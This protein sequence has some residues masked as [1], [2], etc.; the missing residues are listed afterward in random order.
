MAEAAAPPPFD[1]DAYVD[2]ASRL[3]GIEVAEAFRPGVAA[4]IALIAQDGG[5]GHGPTPFHRGRA[6]AG[7]RADRARAMIDPFTSGV[8]IATLIRNGEVSAV[9]VAEAALA[10]IAAEDGRLNSFTTVT[11]ERALAEAAA[12]DAARARGDALPPLAGVPYAVKNLFDLAGVVTAAGS[13]IERDQPP[14]GA[15]A[16]LVGRMRAAGAVLRRRAQH[17]RI[18]LRLHH[19][20][21]A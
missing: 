14:A 7:V 18:R 11:A 2:Q 1:A 20:E 8:A 16:F 21:R 17:G 15:D 9:A 5:P 12:V 3:V 6:G 4:N 19:R 13:K 10:R